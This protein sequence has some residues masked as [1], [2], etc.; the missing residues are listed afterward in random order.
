[1]DLSWTASCTV[2]SHAVKR[3]T[4]SGTYTQTVSALTTISYSDA[5][6]RHRPV[7]FAGI[8]LILLK[9]TIVLTCGAA[10]IVGVGRYGLLLRRESWRRNRK[11]RG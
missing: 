1:M 4:V 11:Q 2:T 7:S 5:I 8:L 10:G 3:G 9:H 6:Q